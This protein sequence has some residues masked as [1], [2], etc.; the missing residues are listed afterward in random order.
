[1]HPVITQTKTAAWLRRAITGAAIACCVL[2]P[3][4]APAQAKPA[5]PL[6]WGAV[7]GKQLTGE[8][9]PWDLNA[10][11]KFENIAHKGASL[12]AF[13]SPFADCSLRPCSYFYFPTKG[14]ETL[15]QLG[16]IPMLNWASQSVPS[17]VSLKEPAF[18]LSDV[19]AGAYD[20]YI[21]E[22]AEQVRE[23]GHPFFLRFDQEM[24]GFWFPWNEGVNGNKSGEF[25]AA[26]R[27]V[28]DIFTE[29]GATNA[30]WVWCPN[31]DFTGKLTPLK[32]QY[33][34]AA[35]V[36]WTCLDGFNWGETPN[37]KGWMSFEG[38]FRSTYNRVLKIAPEKPMLIAEVASEER[39]GS[40]ARWIRNTLRAIPTR[41]PR[42]GGVIWFEENDRGMGWPIESSGA[43]RR[44]FARSISRP[45]YRPN[46]FG[47]IETSPI[48]PLAWP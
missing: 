38:I 3:A 41:F 12:L 32:S 16:T 35:Y 1:M 34:G 33:P 26:W 15:R 17:P 19:I 46:E 18:Q 43:A 29:V 31:V 36:D 40:K 22:F 42:I 45:V 27:H 4:T 30:S 11:Y 23:W 39:G 13:S 37:S 24:N 10:L 6:Y 20:E 25:V 48:P 21:R 5:K 14:M 8:A 44:A 28:H 47:G 7:I 2:L 9:P